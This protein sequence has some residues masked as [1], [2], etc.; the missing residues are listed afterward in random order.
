MGLCAMGVGNLLPFK[1]AKVDGPP[2]TSGSMVCQALAD[3]EGANEVL[4][5]LARTWAGEAAVMRT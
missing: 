5:V 1:S 3:Q 2:V 4:S